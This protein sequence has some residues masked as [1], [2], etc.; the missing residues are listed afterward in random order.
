MLMSKLRYLPVQSKRIV[1]RDKCDI[2][3]THYIVHSKAS[4]NLKTTDYNKPIV[5]LWLITQDIK[6]YNAIS[7]NHDTNVK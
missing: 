4:K 3:P 6:M 7:R 5:T 1:L 2:P